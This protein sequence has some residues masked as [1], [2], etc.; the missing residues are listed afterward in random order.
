MNKFRVLITIFLC[1]LT[2]AA[3]TATGVSISKEKV[4]YETYCAEAEQYM[5]QG[6]YQKAV[7][8]LEKALEIKEEEPTRKMLAAA[9]QSAYADGA[10]TTACAQRNRLA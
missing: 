3:W 6:L 7:S 1:G 10:V 8:S 4:V 5:A 9:Y 2:A